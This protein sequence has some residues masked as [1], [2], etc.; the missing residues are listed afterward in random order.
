MQT[1]LF[2]LYDATLIMETSPLAAQIFSWL[3]AGKWRLLGQYGLYGAGV[4]MGEV[5]T[6]ETS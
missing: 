4:G 3:F 2:S 6:P 5:L 1:A